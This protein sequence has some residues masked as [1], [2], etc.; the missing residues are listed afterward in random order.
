MGLQRER[1][2]KNLFW[3]L[4]L[5]VYEVHMGN[6]IACCVRKYMT[7]SMLNRE[8]KSILQG[9]VINNRICLKRE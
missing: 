5:V 8:N 1:L 4:Q 6:S 3:S 2:R 9:F 7:H